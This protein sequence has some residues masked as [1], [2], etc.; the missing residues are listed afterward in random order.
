MV[1]TD[2]GGGDEGSRELDLVVEGSSGGWAIVSRVLETISLLQL[3]VS[4]T[5][6]V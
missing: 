1:D 2:W 3:F 6:A 5:T 4:C